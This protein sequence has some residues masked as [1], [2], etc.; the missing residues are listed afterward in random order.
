M[1]ILCET[2]RALTYLHGVSSQAFEP[3]AFRQVSLRRP[4]QLKRFAK[5][6]GL[7][8]SLCQ[9][10]PAVLHRD[11]KPSNILLD[12]RGTAL[13]ADVGMAKA[14]AAGQTQVTQP[15]GFGFELEP[16]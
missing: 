3:P 15:C 6:D 1:R 14:G 7:N 16:P 9:R 13:L 11:V 5:A 10:T 12:T 4:P 2:L 8:P